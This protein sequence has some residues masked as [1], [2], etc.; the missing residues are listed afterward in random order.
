MKKSKSRKLELVN[1]RVLIV[2]ID[3]GKRKHFARFLYADR[4]I[5]GPFSFQN[6]REGFTK[7]TD[8][9]LKLINEGSYHSAVVG[10]E[11]TGHYWKPLA[12]H[13]D[14]FT[15]LRLVQVNPAHVKK[16]KEIYDSSPGKTDQK[17]PGV[18]AMLIQMGKFQ[19]L[20]LPKGEF[21]SLRIYS[22][23]R[24]QKVVEFGMQRNIL[25]SLV[26]TIFPEYG[27][28]FQKLESKTSLHILE[29]Y[30]TPERLV[31]EGPA[32]LN[33]IL[34]KVS[35]GKLSAD[36]ARKLFDA[37]QS[38]VGTKEGLEAV[39]FAIR[40]TVSNIKRIQREISGIEKLMTNALS[41][42]SYAEK[43]LSIHGIGPVSLSMILGEIGDIRRYRKAEE[44]LKLA[45]LNLYEISSGQQKGRR[46]ISKRGRPLLRKTLFYAALRMV[47]TKGVFRPDYLRLTENNKMH[48]TKALVAL[49]RKLLRVIFAL[50]RNN[51]YF[52]HSQAEIAL[53]A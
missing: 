42:I 30:S 48:K 9:V 14:R 46:R 32:R 26:D 40:S 44:I 15:D 11:S 18:I 13:L 49:S 33:A 34:R 45:G 38:S 43:L 36:R 10:L 31:N 37:A 6:T 16:A 29:H 4:H 39:V 12:Y 51:V 3:I 20:V 50:A 21:A 5:S 17:D 41:K 7:L 23:Q 25:H 24:E 28:V 27:S 52:K 35:R 19:K 47:K 2:G 1:N 8:K 22:R 53:A